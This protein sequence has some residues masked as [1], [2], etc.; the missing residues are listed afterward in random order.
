MRSL[1]AFG[2]LAAAAAVTAHDF[3]T[4]GG[5]L[6]LDDDTFDAALDEFDTLLVEFYAPWCGH[7]K[8]LK[9]PYE[10]AAKRLAADDLYIAK[11][12]ATANRELGD[13]FEVRGFPTLKFFRNGKATDYDGGRT[14]DE[15]FNWVSKKSGP[16]A[17]TLDGE[18]EVE[19]FK[20]SAEVV[21][22]GSFA[23][24]ESDNAKAFVAAAGDVDEAM[25]G[26]TTTDGDDTVTVFKSFDEGRADFDGD[27]TSSS[28]IA[29]FVRG[30]L[31]PLVVDFNDGTASK[32]FGG[33][34][35]V[36]FLV[37]SDPDADEH[38][39]IVSAMRD[40]AGA[41]KGQALFIT[42]APTE[43][44]VMQ[45][46]DINEADLPTAFLVNMP[47]GEQMRK[48]EFTSG[49]FTSDGLSGFV[50][51]FQAGSLK[52]HLKSAEPED[53]DLDG[54]VVEV[55]GKTFDDIVLDEEKDVLIAF[56]APWCGHCKNMKPKFKK[57]AKQFAGADSVV[58][59][60][61]DATANEVDVPGV[62]VQGFPT[63]FFFP[64]GPDQSAQP[65]NGGRDTDDFVK[66]IEENARSD[67]EVSA[68]D[69]ERDEL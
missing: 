68:G 40:A 44:R 22:V 66:F 29:T 9:K 53:D 36:H 3:E 35:K 5:V 28:D 4:E 48:F 21:V 11:V 64:A 61:I 58:F 32:I 12:D 55:R 63:L 30:N 67:F 14:A 45:Y 6:V 7:C 26:I 10:K 69:E 62:N 54:P 47:D 23:D 2:L 42:V 50:D 49:D 33:P 8:Q 34:V 43:S 31:L 57:A 59:A 39:G 51:A 13:R 56:T 17:K 1:I 15:I 16:P 65:F 27:L 46:F 24:A 52:P 18:E 38:E 41:Y 20:T 37:F 19:A 25:F 60:N